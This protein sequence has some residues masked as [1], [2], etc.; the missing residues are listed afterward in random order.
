M[1]RNE[2]FSTIVNIH[3]PLKMGL[4]MIDHVGW[5]PSQGVQMHSSRTIKVTWSQTV[6]RDSVRLLEKALEKM[7][8]TRYNSSKSHM[9]MSMVINQDSESLKSLRTF[10][11]LKLC[12]FYVSL[13]CYSTRYWSAYQ[14]QE[15]SEGFESRGRDYLTR[16]GEGASD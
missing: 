9:Q 1:E 4:S 15:A 11:S 7:K 3:N 14:I 13:L 6:N 16:Q 10:T 5:I 12:Q 2:S 8:S